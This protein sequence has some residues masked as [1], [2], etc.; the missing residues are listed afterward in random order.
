MAVS[1]GST[2]VSLYDAKTLTK[3]ATLDSPLT[4]FDC[5][6]AFSADSRQLAIAGGVSRVVLWDLAWLKHELAPDGLAW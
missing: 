2:E 5:T 3:I 4:P 1:S 6:L